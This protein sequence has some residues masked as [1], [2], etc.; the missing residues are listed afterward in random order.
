MKKLYGFNAYFGRMGSL[1]GLFI[2]DDNLVE[3]AIGR[4]VYFGEVLG[5]HSNIWCLLNEDHFKVITDDQELISKLES[6]F[7]S[8]NGIVSISGYNPLDYVDLDDDD[9][10]D[11][12]EY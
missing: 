1:D 12:L 6:H 3:K 7:A 4:R 10:E 8:D 2:A 11:D 9:E 5:K